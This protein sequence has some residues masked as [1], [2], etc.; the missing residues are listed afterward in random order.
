MKADQ[1][2]TSSYFLNKTTSCQTFEIPLFSENKTFFTKSKSQGMLKNGNMNASSKYPN[3][4]SLKSNN[5]IKKENI[6]HSIQ[7]KTKPM[8]KSIGLST[9]KINCSSQGTQTFPEKIMIDSWT[10]TPNELKNKELETNLEN[11]S[12][13]VQKTEY[14]IYSQN[15]E[16][17]QKTIQE[18][19]S[20]TSDHDYNEKK[21]LTKFEIENLFKSVK[22]MVN[23]IK[24]KDT[25]TTNNSQNSISLSQKLDIRNLKESTDMLIQK[26]ENIKK[27]QAE[28]FLK[29][30]SLQSSDFMLSK[31]E[32]AF[33]NFDANLNN[34]NNNISQKHSNMIESRLLESYCF[35]SQMNA[36]QQN[37]D[38]FNISKSIDF[39]EKLLNSQM[40]SNILATKESKLS[41][42]NN[43]ALSTIENIEQNTTNQDNENENELVQSKVMSS[44]KNLPQQYNGSEFSNIPLLLMENQ[45]HTENKDKILIFDQE[46]DKHNQEKMAKYS[47]GIEKIE[48][49]AEEIN[50]SPNNKNNK[51]ENSNSEEIKKV[52]Q[53]K[54]FESTR[55]LSKMQINL[56][57]L[58]ESKK[59]PNDL[60][61]NGLYSHLF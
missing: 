59:K 43:I 11:N 10:Q 2:K 5:N 41:N 4:G 20:V 53:E 24:E 9:E 29:Q 45:K 25:K 17:T 7:A 21:K 57:F 22:N 55:N 32:S 33:P 56:P 28:V 46:Q 37:N 48:E 8:K 54:K 35:N 16:D 31:S 61:K 13:N 12:S 18:M 42:N 47:S 6:A 40:L 27:S 26:L 51:L 30:S 3:T 52:L 39:F 1:H 58:K 38:D 15:K 23:G 34:T 14:S 60:Y 49:K 19:S 36:N 50:F 44:Y